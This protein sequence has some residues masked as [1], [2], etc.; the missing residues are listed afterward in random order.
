MFL[1]M[2]DRKLVEG[3]FVFVETKKGIVKNNSGLAQRSSALTHGGKP[4]IKAVPY[5]T[6]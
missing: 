5:E 6:I 2:L 3:L 4:H 1:R